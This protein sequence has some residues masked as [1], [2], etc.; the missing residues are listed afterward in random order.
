[1]CF[2]VCCNFRFTEIFYRNFF[3][4]RLE[5]ISIWIAHIAKPSRM[6][7]FQNYGGITIKIATTKKKT[8]KWLIIFNTHAEKCG[9]FLPKFCYN[10]H[11]SAQ[12]LLQWTLISLFQLS[13]YWLSDWHFMGWNGIFMI[14]YRF[15][16]VL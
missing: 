9:E 1:M 13:N 14:P 7:S 12:V 15:F 2:S 10:F 5:F 6:F 16:C 8:M 11:L 3:F 4:L